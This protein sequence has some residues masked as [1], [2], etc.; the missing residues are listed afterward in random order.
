VT[1]AGKGKLIGFDEWVGRTGYILSQFVDLF[2]VEPRRIELI[3]LQTLL[4]IPCLGDNYQRIVT[5]LLNGSAAGRFLQSRKTQDIN[6]T[7]NVGVPADKVCV[8]KITSTQTEG[9]LLRRIAE[10]E[11][12]DLDYVKFN[13]GVAHTDFSSFRLLDED[14]ITRILN[15]AKMFIIRDVFDGLV[16]PFEPRQD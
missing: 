4:Y 5:Q 8:V 16:E 11:E 1:T 10:G 7:F 3:D 2:S 13:I 6:L 14:S 15:E 12:A 9:S